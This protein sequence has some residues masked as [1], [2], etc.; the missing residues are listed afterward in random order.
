MIDYT[1]NLIKDK[2]SNFIM[3]KRNDGKWNLP[4][5]KVEKNESIFHCASRET[6]EE[7]GIK[8]K[9]ENFKLLFNLKYYYEN[10]SIYVMYSKINNFSSE[11][12]DKYLITNGVFLSKMQNIVEARRL[13]YILEKVKELNF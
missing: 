3:I 12:N 5:G 4:G 11:L 2:Y 13:L 7:T 10:A 9:S 1:L 8:I 6:K